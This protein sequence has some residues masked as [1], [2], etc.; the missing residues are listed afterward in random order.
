MNDGGAHRG[1]RH[2]IAGAVTLAAAAQA[3]VRVRAEGHLPSTDIARRIHRET[4]EAAHAELHA[5]L[6]T[7]AVG[8]WNDLPSRTLTDIYAA[9]SPRPASA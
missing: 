5:R 2:D 6:G 8:V 4:W 7:D 9:L 1:G 3:T